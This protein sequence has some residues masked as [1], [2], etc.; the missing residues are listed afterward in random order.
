QFTDDGALVWDL[1]GFRERHTVLVNGRP[2]PYFEVAAR[3]YRLRL[4][5][6]SNERVFS[7]RLGE[8]EE[9]THIGTDGG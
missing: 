4:V 7:L 3:K 1:H 5:N 9:F 2:R 8:D 6:T